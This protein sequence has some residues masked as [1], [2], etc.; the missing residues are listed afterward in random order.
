MSFQADLAWGERFIPLV[1]RIVGPQ[2]LTVSPLEVDQKRAA[3]LILMRAEPIELGVRIRGQRYLR[4]YPHDFTI[5]YAR[6]NGAR[7]EFSKVMDGLMTHMFYGHALSDNGPPEFSRYF[8]LDMD[9]FRDE[10]RLA[11]R[12]RAFETQMIKRIPNGDGT[13]LLACDMRRFSP[14]LILDQGALYTETIGEHQLTF[15]EAYP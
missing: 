11:G 6:D 14:D 9:V 3:D 5:R 4:S 2:L 12:E 15:W 8:L 13:H 7:T 1:K 10:L